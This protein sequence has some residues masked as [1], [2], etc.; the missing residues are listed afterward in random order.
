ME[1]T[2]EQ[3]YGEWQAQRGCLKYPIIP[4]CFLIGALVGIIFGLRQVYGT[5]LREGIQKGTS[6]AT[7]EFLDKNIFRVMRWLKNL[8]PPVVLSG[9]LKWAGGSNLSWYTNA[10]YLRAIFMSY[11]KR[12]YTLW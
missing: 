12:R 7:Y 9:S 11:I 5:T 10:L 8:N 4:Y 6:E 1:G 2:Q 3:L